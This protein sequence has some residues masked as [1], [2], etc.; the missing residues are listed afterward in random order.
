MKLCPRVGEIMEE[1]IRTVRKRKP[2][3]E[4]KNDDG[5]FA[6]G[7]CQAI[8][9]VIIV[10]TV[11]FISKSKG[12]AA[13]NLKDDFALLMSISYSKEDVQKTWSSIK[14]Y[15]DSP[16]SLS[17]FKASSEKEETTTE[18]SE[19]KAG[20]TAPK[21]KST[22]KFEEK[23]TTVAAASETEK[24]KT[25]EET[26]TAAKTNLKL[27]KQS[28]SSSSVKVSKTETSAA[29][30]T[31]QQIIMPVSGTYTSYFGARTNP[32]TGN[33]SFHT[34]LDIAAAQGTKIKAA[35]SGV[36]RKVGEDSRSG[37]YIYLTHKDGVETLYCHCSAV[38]A[39]EGAS[40]RQGETI[41]LVGST[42]WSTGP[43]LH[44]EFHKNGER[45]D[46]LPILNDK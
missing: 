37:K 41:A 20:T 24:E 4:N 15:F 22:E 35:Y 31:E 6:V 7:L 9:A 43:H 45:L 32:I 23:K 29:K 34:G 38:L 18:Q 17:V 11:L 3:G 33:D 44:F 8:F 46:P 21:E 14:S 28:E 25:T 26:T 19:D 13:Q 40:I 39:E 36:V 12:T 30:S 42:G 16:A 27:S 2:A 5:L 1:N 10:L